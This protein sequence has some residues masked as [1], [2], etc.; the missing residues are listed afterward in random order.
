M[1]AA[2]YFMRQLPAGW[3][4]AALGIG[5][6]IFFVVFIFL[7]ICIFVD[8][9][10]RRFHDIGQSGLLVLVFLVPIVGS[11][12]FLVL[13]FLPGEAIQNRYGYPVS[14]LGFKRILFN[15]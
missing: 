13:F 12:T 3:L 5:A 11:I 2:S 4:S 6:I 8:I 9:S 1:I 7:Y 15:K 10:M 14:G